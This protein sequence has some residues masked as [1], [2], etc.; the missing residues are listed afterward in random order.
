MIQLAHLVIL[1]KFVFPTIIILDE[2]STYLVRP[3]K[4]M[5]LGLHTI[6][7]GREDEEMLNKSNFM[8]FSIHLQLYKN[9]QEKC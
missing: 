9:F 7:V 5:C 8:A 1:Q 3:K 2:N 6:R 4:I